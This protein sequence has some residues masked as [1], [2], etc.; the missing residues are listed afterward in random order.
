M[1]SLR[2]IGNWFYICYILLTGVF[3]SRGQSLDVINTGE[4]TCFQTA[5]WYTG[6]VCTTVKESFSML[7]L[8]ELDASIKKAN[9][10]PVYS[11]I[12]VRIDHDRHILSETDKALFNV[13]KY[14]LENSRKVDISGFLASLVRIG[15]VKWTRIRSGNDVERRCQSR[16]G[17]CPEQL[18]FEVIYL[19]GTA[20][21]PESYEL[22]KHGVVF[23]LIPTLDM[24]HCQRAEQ[25]LRRQRE[26]E[27]APS[28]CKEVTQFFAL[29]NFY[30]I[31][32]FA[33][34]AEKRRMFSGEITESIIC[35][36]GGTPLGRCE[37]LND[38][39][40]DEL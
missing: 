12:V 36:P 17:A 3:L 14:W 5:S 25:F 27:V 40:G 2:A 13:P 7:D 26:T 34:N 39:P 21:R 9:R 15:D 32:P 8:D 18:E 1:L 31:Y 19:F 28:L 16:G 35:E 6:F 20:V 23:V 22:T 24:E 10:S 29:R 33:T 30:S 4:T 37:Y 38:E 11:I